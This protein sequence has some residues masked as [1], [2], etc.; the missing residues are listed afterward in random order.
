MTDREI[1]DETDD[2]GDDGPK[3]LRATVERQAK[4]LAGLKAEKRDRALEDSGL[5][6]PALKAV[7]K[8]LDREEYDGEISATAFQKYAQEEYDWEPPSDDDTDD[9][10]PPPIDEDTQRRM[11]SQRTRDDVTASSHARGD[12]SEDDDEA[13]YNE[14]QR[15]LDEGDVQGAV[16]TELNTKV[17]RARK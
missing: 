13:R 12:D 15:Q 9:D 7:K 16:L 4:E 10:T 11:D 6:G 8:D 2:D 17:A 3:G 14:Q 1:T 5:D